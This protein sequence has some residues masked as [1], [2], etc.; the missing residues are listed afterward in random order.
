MFNH[1][2]GPGASLWIAFYSNIE[3]LLSWDFRDIELSWYLLGFGLLALWAGIYVLLSAVV[4]WAI[5]AV[6]AVFLKIFRDQGGQRE[7][8]KEI[9]VSNNVP[10]AD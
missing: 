8:P 9:G 10:R 6:A 3:P 5:A 4:G 2:K 7:F 1:D